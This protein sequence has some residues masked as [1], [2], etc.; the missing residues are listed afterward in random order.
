MSTWTPE[1]ALWLVAGLLLKHF[2]CDGPLQT[3]SMVRRKASY[4]DPLGLVHAG[5]HALG[6]GLVI[7]LAG[8]GAGL[9]AAMGLADGIIHYHADYLKETLVRR[10]GWTA[11][12]SAYWWTLAV[13][14]GFHNLT[15]IAIA[16]VVVRSS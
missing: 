5:T 11:Q 8:A 6:S 9:A 14:Q 13:D 3:P 10:R 1:G 4:G 16:A 12:D 15:Y 2:L 7:L